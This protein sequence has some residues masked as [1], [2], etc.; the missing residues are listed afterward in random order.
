L[1]SANCELA[2]IGAG[3]TGLS[4]AYS[5]VNRGFNDIVILEMGNLAS[6][7]SSRNGG[8]IRA[9]FSTEEN[10]RLAR[11]SIDRFRKL[12]AELNSNFWFR[13]GGYLFLAESDQ[14][15]AEL[16]KAAEFHSRYGLGTRI[17]DGEQIGR[18]VPCLDTGGFIGGS[19]RK[20][21]GILFPFPLLYGYAELL[22]KHGVRIETR[23]EAKAIRRT[24][25]GF[26]LT[27][28]RGSVTSRRVLNAAGGWSNQVSSMMGS[29]VPTKPVRHQIM[30][31]EPLSP[32]LDPMVVTLKDGFYISQGPRGELI[33]GITER[34]EAYQDPRRSGFGFCRSISARM[35]GL[36]PRL[37][38]AKMM[39]QWAGFYDMSPDA[40]PIL[41]ELPGLG[42]AFIACGFSGHGFMI[43]PAVGEMMAALILGDKPPFPREPYMLSRFGKGTT[44]R[45]SLVIG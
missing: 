23:C 11:W 15:L 42:G 44:S 21:D 24:S 28:S 38:G 37:S 20:S 14:E 32:F 13:Q 41:D 10:I 31:S 7:A 35:I 45:E 5:L 1:M 8:G 4:T 17:L 33:G 9:Q 3:V 22:R 27:T 26:Q 30:A 40:N 12:G 39:R 2:I 19:Y 29:S 36:C 34:S 25:E 18:I 6:G 16:R 43:S